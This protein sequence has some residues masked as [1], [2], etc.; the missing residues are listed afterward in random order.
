MKYDV[1]KC[2]FTKGQGQGSHNYCTQVSLVL[3]LI[4][5]AFSPEGRERKGTG[6]DQTSL[7][8]P[9]ACLIFMFPVLRGRVQAGA[10]APA[11]SGR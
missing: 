8:H 11:L 1:A 9:D 2:D 6:W 4:K 3:G 10:G 7:A 5:A